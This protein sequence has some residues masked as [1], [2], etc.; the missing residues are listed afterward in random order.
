VGTE[1]GRNRDAWAGTLAHLRLRLDETDGGGRP[2]VITPHTTVGRDDRK[3]ESLRA[4]LVDWSGEAPFAFEVEDG[5][6]RSVEGGAPWAAPLA[7]ED[8]VGRPAP[9]ILDELRTT[10]GVLVDL[11]LDAEPGVNR[12]S[13]SV[14]TADGWLEL[15]L[16]IVEWHVG[17]ARWSRTMI[18]ANASV[19]AGRAGRG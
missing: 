18:A 19:G 2:V 17:L 7:A 13:C 8:W 1:L 11:E 12:A 15:R 16:V 10:L 14:Q 3:F 4:D 5:V 6:V 9:A